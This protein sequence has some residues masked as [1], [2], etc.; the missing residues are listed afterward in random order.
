MKKS[1]AGFA[2]A[3]L[4]ATGAAQATTDDVSVNLAL[5]GTARNS[6][7]MCSVALN[8]NAI[9]ITGDLSNMPMQGST[10]TPARQII[11]SIIGGADCNKLVEQK[12]IAYKLMGTADSADGNVLAN[13]FTGENAASG[14]GIG[15]YDEFGNVIPINSGMLMAKSQLSTLLGLGAVKLNNQTRVGGTLQGSLTVE[16]ERL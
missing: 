13:E 15:L 16:I 1:M 3:I 2:I 7:D 11:V 10:A 9:N 8:T 12:R 14:I 4:L 6:D 5:T